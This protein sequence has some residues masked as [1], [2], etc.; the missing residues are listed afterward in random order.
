M[1]GWSS[2]RCNWPS[3][4]TTTSKLRLTQRPAIGISNTVPR[5]LLLFLPLMFPALIAAAKQRAAAP[6]PAPMRM[7]LASDAEGRWVAFTLTPGNQIS[8]HTV[9]DGRD[10]LAIL[11]TGVSQSLMSRRF[12]AVNGFAVTPGGQANAIG[13]SVQIDTT[14]IQRLAI[15]GLMREGGT[16]AVLSIPP[17]ATGGDRPVDLLIGQDLLSAVALDIDYARSRF[18]VLR[19]GRIPFR[20]SAAPLALVDGI[21]AAVTETQLGADR[22]HAMMID[23]GDGASVTFA[24][25]S[26]H[27]DAGITGAKTTAIS[28]GLAGPLITDLAIAPRLSI[29][30]L[31]AREVEVRIEPADGYSRKIGVAGR[32]GNGLLSRYRVLIDPRAG[33]VMFLNNRNADMPPVKSTSGIQTVTEPGHL[34]V[35]HIMRGSPAETGGWRAG[36]TICSVDATAIGTDYDKSTLAN[37][38]IDKPGRTITLGLCDGRV[39][40]L[41]LQQFY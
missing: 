30:A 1:A 38:S 31:T 13:G 26:W 6:P 34:R 27:G 5:L 10:A 4:G 20:G 23:T 9:I 15:G 25:E 19:S 24:R 8:F 29:G 3:D 40:T 7:A 33:H 21:N 18:R 14:L 35:L 11:D 37:W 2:P 16:L 22:Q 12:A 28:Y 36:E 39:R 41:T 17:R 32:I